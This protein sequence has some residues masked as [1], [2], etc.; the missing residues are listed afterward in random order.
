MQS[1][2]GAV[3]TQLLHL[4]GVRAEGSEKK[5]GV[6]PLHTSRLWW[7]WGRVELP[8]ALFWPFLDVLQ[9]LYDSHCLASLLDLLELALAVTCSL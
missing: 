6:K 5:R 3:A 1:K 4:G 2:K 7:R 9:H 8:A